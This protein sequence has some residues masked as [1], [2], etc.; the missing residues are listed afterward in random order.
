MAM[1]KQ[2]YKNELFDEIAGGNIT[3]PSS[4]SSSNFKWFVNMW[5]DIKSA[6]TNLRRRNLWINKKKAT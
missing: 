3:N 6:P 4:L 1:S 2:I 5:A